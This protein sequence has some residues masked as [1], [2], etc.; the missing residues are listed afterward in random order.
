MRLMKEVDSTKYHCNCEQESERLKTPFYVFDEI[1]VKLTI[2]RLI[3][4]YKNVAISCRCVA[5]DGIYKQKV[6]CGVSSKHISYLVKCLFTS[7]EI[8]DAR[9]E[10][11]YEHREKL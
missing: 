5:N 2:M 10:Q 8:H 9:G 11:F 7:V 6:T 3:S 1:M 4:S